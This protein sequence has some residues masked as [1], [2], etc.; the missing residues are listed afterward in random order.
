MTANLNLVLVASDADS[1]WQ[2]EH[3][4]LELSPIYQDKPNRD[5]LVER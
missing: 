3:T 4:W 2:L 1:T 5:I